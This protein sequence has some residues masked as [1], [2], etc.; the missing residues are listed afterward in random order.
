MTEGFVWL[1]TVN[2]LRSSPAS[3]TM[4]HVTKIS[5]ALKPSSFSFRRKP[6]PSRGH[7]KSPN[8]IPEGSCPLLRHFGI[9]TDQTIILHSVNS[10]HLKD[11]Q[12]PSFH[13]KC[14]NDDVPHGRSVET[15]P[16]MNESEQNPLKRTIMKQFGGRRA[17]KD[18]QH[19]VT[20]NM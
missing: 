14:S 12:P 16:V 13:P 4:N 3:H 9:Q 8:M 15:V 17:N 6:G 10:P 5:T 1:Q 11:A 19:E 2:A 18:G 20:P 7:R